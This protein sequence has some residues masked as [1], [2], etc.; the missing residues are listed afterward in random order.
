MRMCIDKSRQYNSPS[1]IDNL[2]VARVFPD[3]LTR[4]DDVDL[5]VANQHSAVANDREVGH[6]VADT[7]TLRT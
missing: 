6:F 7:R 2:R 1:C 4:A 3:L 5:A